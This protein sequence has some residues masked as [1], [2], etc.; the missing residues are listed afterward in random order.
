MYR[1]TPMCMGSTRRQSRRF[2]NNKNHPHVYGE[3]PKHKNRQLFCMESTP[4]VWGVLVQTIETAINMRITPMCM[5]S[6]EY[7]LQNYSTLEN[8]PHVYGEY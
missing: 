7:I 4:C 1:I 6:T 5:G 2:T 8:H 3:Y